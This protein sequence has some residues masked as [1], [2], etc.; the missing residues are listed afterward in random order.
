MTIIRADAAYPRWPE[1]LALLQGAF[2]YMTPLMGHPPGVDSLTASDLADRAEQ[3][4]AWIIEENDASIACLFARRSRDLP[5]AL[6]VNLLAVAEHA[7]GRRLAGQLMAAAEAEARTR[8]FNALTLD[9]G[10]ALAELR[11]IYLRWG[12]TETA[13]DG[14]VVTF[15][16][17]LAS[18]SRKG[19]DA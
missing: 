16:K 6:F 14:E 15:V 19:K 3:G 4:I 2:A 8:G 7:R 17:P 5:G 10:S 12:F 1:V 18:L 13:D 11:A 9:T